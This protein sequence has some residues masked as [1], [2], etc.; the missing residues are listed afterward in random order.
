MYFS[1]FTT[2]QNEMVHDCHQ[3]QFTDS[4]FSVTG[5]SMKWYRLHNRNR[6]TGAAS[7]WMK[8]S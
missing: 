8:L 1:H 2:T 7:R 5:L 3:M 6:S 4:N